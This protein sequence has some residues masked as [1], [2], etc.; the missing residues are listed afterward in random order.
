MALSQDGCTQ[1]QPDINRRAADECALSLVVDPFF[2]FKL[3][4]TQLSLEFQSRLDQTHLRLMSSQEVPQTVY[5]S[6]ITKKK[7]LRHF[8]C[9]PLFLLSEWTGLEPA[10]P[11]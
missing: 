11:A 10:P 4:S 3:L 6:K 7:G 2:G 8:C 5:P 9:N 1:P